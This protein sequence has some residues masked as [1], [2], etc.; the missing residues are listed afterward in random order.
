[1]ENSATVCG[2]HGAL[3]SRARS[4]RPRAHHGSCLRPGDAGAPAFLRDD[5]GDS[6]HEARPQDPWV[7]NCS[8][9][10]EP[11]TQ[12]GRR[13]LLRGSRHAPLKAASGGRAQRAR[14]RGGADSESLA[15]GR[16]LASSRLISCRRGGWARASGG[17]RQSGPRAG[18]AGFC[19][20][21]G[22]S[23]QRPGPARTALAAARR[24]RCHAGARCFPRKRPDALIAPSGRARRM[25]VA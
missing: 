10:G 8:D 22:V 16:G 21:L 2:C 23:P 11:A 5:C 25:L 6:V 17:R 13:R 15:Q 19:G 3:R 4:A 20:T 24:R 18:P 12:G 9:L 14:A 1:M 7:H